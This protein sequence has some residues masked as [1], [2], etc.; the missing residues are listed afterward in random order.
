MVA[1]TRVERSKTG[2]HGTD[3][4]A[5]PHP[6]VFVQLSQSNSGARTVSAELGFPEQIA[7]IIE[8]LWRYEEV[9]LDELINELMFY[10]SGVF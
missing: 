6:L 3:Y 2:A 4:W 5:H 9:D 10:L 7:K 8:R 1:P